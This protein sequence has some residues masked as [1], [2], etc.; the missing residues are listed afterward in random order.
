MKTK[1]TLLCLMLCFGASAQPTNVYSTNTLPVAFGK[2]NANFN[3]LYYLITNNT[4]GGGG[5]GYYVPITN[6]MALDLTATNSLKLETGRYFPGYIIFT[7]DFAVSHSC[8]S[9]AGPFYNYPPTN[10]YIGYTNSCGYFFYVDQ[11]VTNYST[12]TNRGGPYYTNAALAGFTNT[13]NM[14]LPIGSLC[15]NSAGPFW[16][17]IPLGGY[18]NECGYMIFDITLPPNIQTNSDLETQLSVS[19]IRDLYTLTVSGGSAGMDGTYTFTNGTFFNG[20]LE[21]AFETAGGHWKGRNGV[22][23]YDITTLLGSHGSFGTVAAGTYSTT[24]GFNAKNYWPQWHW[25]VS[26]AGD[27]TVAGEYWPYG[28]SYSYSVPLPTGYTRSGVGWRFTNSISSADLNQAAWRDRSAVAVTGTTSTYY[29]SIMSSFTNH[30]FDLGTLAPKPY[31][32]RLPYPQ[33][34]ES[35]IVIVPPPY[36]TGTG[37]N[38]GTLGSPPRIKYNGPSGCFYLVKSE[39]YLASV[40]SMNEAT[41]PDISSSITVDQFGTATLVIFHVTTKVIP[42]SDTS[43]WQPCP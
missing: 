40:N 13:C 24:Y 4:F 17:N 8:T 27:S 12:C 21:I 19:G 9:T 7:D 42:Q 28:S 36:Y 1:F 33:T 5:S 16:E 39:Q 29:T 23:Q 15:T 11:V 2:V 22:S 20:S 32:F 43:E 41:D 14:L 26:S 10:G 34:N 30:T 25:I 31:A 37:T 18:T 35:A 38:T 6:G 3:W